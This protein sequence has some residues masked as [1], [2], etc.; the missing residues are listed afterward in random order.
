MRR[1]RRGCDETG[2]RGAVNMTLLILDLLCLIVVIEI[3][4]RAK[5]LPWHD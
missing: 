3:V 4:A 2:D 1:E 5:P